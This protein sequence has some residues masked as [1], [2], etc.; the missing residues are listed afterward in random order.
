MQSEV[1][2][3]YGKTLQNTEDLQT[4]ACCTADRPPDH[5][6]PVLSKIHDEVLSR[7]YGCGLI[8]PEALSGSGA[9][10]TTWLPVC[11]E[12]SMSM[13][14]TTV[15]VPT[16]QAVLAERIEELTTLFKAQRKRQGGRRGV[17]QRRDEFW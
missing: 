9:V 14:S 1:Q 12:A 16:T 3:Y 7:Y 17:A 4:N 13:L 2:E 10:A 11:C 5:I 6:R 15:S 8:A